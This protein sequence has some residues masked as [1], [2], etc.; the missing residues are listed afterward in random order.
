MP[1]KAF[2]VQIDKCDLPLLAGCRKDLLLHLRRDEEVGFGAEEI[3]F[4]L[5]SSNL[6]CA[7]GA[8]QDSQNTC[9]GEA[10]PRCQLAPLLFVK[11]HEVCIDFR[12]QGDCLCLSSMKL[13]QESLEQPGASRSSNL[14]PLRLNGVLNR[15]LCNWV[16]MGREFFSHGTGYP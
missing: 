16:G 11:E 6:T 14:Y 8:K 13:Q 2:P 4:W 5:D 9:D 15:H 12:R 3:H 10:D 7:L 1:R